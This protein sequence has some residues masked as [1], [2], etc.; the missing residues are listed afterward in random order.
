MPL[1]RHKS[2][3]AW[4][5]TS[6]TY[7][8]ATIRVITNNNYIIRESSKTST[9]SRPPTTRTAIRTSVY[10]IT[11]GLLL[12][13]RGR[14]RILR[15]KNCSALC[16]NKRNEKTKT[17]ASPFRRGFNPCTF[18]YIVHYTIRVTRV[19]KIGGETSDFSKHSNFEQ[20][21]FS[22]RMKIRRKN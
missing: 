5:S 16:G 9:S 14:T 3:V 18:H 17:T 11:I 22:P 19:Q 7:P 1:Y 10:P 6:G 4:R 2:T 20:V 12:L 15:E 8:V 21:L 13:L